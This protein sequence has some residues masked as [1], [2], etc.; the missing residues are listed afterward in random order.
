MAAG[1]TAR[2]VVVGTSAVALGAAHHLRYWFRA[3]L[4]GLG[5]APACSLAGVATAWG[6]A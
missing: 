5:A 1:T 3:A 2:G 6:G 4:I